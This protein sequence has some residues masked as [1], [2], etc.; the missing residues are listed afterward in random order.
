MK[1]EKKLYQKLCCAA[2]VFPRRR[3]TAILKSQEV[4]SIFLKLKD[5]QTN[6]KT[7]KITAK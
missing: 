3:F 6:K 7:H 5:K 1:N 2:I 4:Y